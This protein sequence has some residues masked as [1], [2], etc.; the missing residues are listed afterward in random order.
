MQL[1]NPSPS[2]HNEDLAPARTQ[3]GGRS[4]SSTSGPRTF[5]ASGAITLPPAC[6][7]CAATSST[8][9]WPS[10]SARWSST[11]DADGRAGGRADRR[12]LSGAGAGLVRHL[13]GQRSG[14]RA[15]DCRLLLVWRAD[16]G[17]IGGHRGA[18]DPLARDAGVSTNSHMLGH[19]TLEV[20]CYVDRL[21]AAAADHPARHGDGAQVPGLGRARGVDHDAAA[22]GLSG[23]QV[24]HLLASGEIPQDVLLQATRTPACR[25][26]RARFVRR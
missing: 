16:L 15:G 18:A 8:S 26:R 1:T 2:L 17:R 6:S 7:C 10:G 19:S 24:G 5:T 4:R 25:A 3:S 22:G 11:P 13:R 21:G 14:D 23:G 9:C 20:I 12:A